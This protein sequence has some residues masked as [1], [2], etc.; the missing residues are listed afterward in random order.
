[1]S[2]VTRLGRRP[3]EIAIVNAIT[4]MG[5]AL[6]LALVAEGIE[7]ADKLRQVHELGCQLGQ[8]YHLGRPQ[9]AEA[10]TERLVGKQ[11]R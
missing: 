2:L 6:G 9:R 3:E 10:L 7:D 4:S 11:P 1:M 8:G 5:T